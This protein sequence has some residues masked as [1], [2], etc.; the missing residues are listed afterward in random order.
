MS[1]TRRTLLAGAVFLPCA[2]ARPRERKRVA[3]VTTV[4]THNSH[5]DVILSRLLQGE[6]LDFKSRR[7]D[8]ELVSLY[9]DQFPET[10]MSRRLQREHGFRLTASIGEA[11]TLGGDR[12]AV[13]GVLL[14]GEHGVYP[15]GP[16]GEET[17]PRRRFFDEAVAVFEASKR[18]VPVF[19][20]KH[21]SHT[22]ADS[23]AM[24]D[25]ARRLGFPLMAGSSV[26]LTW[27]R[28]SLDVRAGARLKEA[29]AVSYHTLYGYGFHALEML[30]CL[31]E[32]R[33]GGET[34][35]RRVQTLE[36]PAV[37]EEGRFDIR[38]L[39]EALAHLTRPVRGA[40][41]AQRLATL[42]KD[43]PRPVAF[44]IEYRDG[45]KATVLTLNH[46]IGEWSI[47]WRQEGAPDAEAALFW[48]QEARPLGHF[49][50]LV[51]GIEEM[52]HTGKPTWPVERTLLTSGMMSFLLDSR[53]RGGAVVD[54]PEL[55]IRYKPTFA[56]QDPG[57]PPPS[58]PLDQ[59]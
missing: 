42:K 50:L 13:D 34:G 54:T 14:V 10:D 22:W 19:T 23:R 44:V 15:P 11:L 53:A 29:L 46:A 25:I 58:R 38:L 51:R 37:W 18:S 28:P 20:D 49:S 7:P 30:Q 47:A 43:V 33:R 4:Y 32:R 12:L 1:L 48:T 27:R 59:Q 35:V 9:V 8:L 2:P 3:A 55:N 52:I 57:A 26:P 56:W 39:D 36:G 17:Y 31:A 40:T 6:N 16:R 45:F 41:A 5:A 24:Y 21:L